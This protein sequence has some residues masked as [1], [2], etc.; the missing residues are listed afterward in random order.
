LI[1]FLIYIGIFYFGYRAIKSWMYP[2]E[3]KSEKVSAKAAG[4]IDDVMLKDP[5]CEAYFPERKGVSLKMDGEE[6][7]FCSEECKEKFLAS[8]SGEK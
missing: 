2:S 3:P 6:L 7:L 8:R 5:F 4:Q 1:R